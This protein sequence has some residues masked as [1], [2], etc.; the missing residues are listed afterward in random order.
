[1]AKGPVRELHCS[2][3]C[4]ALRTVYGF[5]SAHHVCRDKAWI[6]EEETE[7]GDTPLT[8]ET[9]PCLEPSEI[10][11]DYAL[12]LAGYGYTGAQM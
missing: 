5:I 12:S 6:G 11:Y 7:K 4:D 10:D 1:M 8:P 9:C 2:K 3:E